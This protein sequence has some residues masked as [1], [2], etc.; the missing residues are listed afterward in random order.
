MLIQ[1]YSGTLPN[2]YNLVKYTNLN[3]DLKIAR[4]V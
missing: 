4:E 2:T 1:G 3:K